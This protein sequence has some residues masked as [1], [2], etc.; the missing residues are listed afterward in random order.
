MRRG[1][2]LPQSDLH[3]TATREDFERAYLMNRP[4]SQTDRVDMTSFNSPDDLKASCLWLI[5]DELDKIDEPIEQLATAIILRLRL[6]EDITSVTH[7]RALR[8]DSINLS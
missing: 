5:P 4:S 1:F 2:S 3:L 7:S 8:M 6:K